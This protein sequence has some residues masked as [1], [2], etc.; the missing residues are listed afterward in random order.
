VKGFTGPNDLYNNNDRVKAV[1][2][3]HIAGKNHFQSAEYPLEDQV[4]GF[5]SIH[6]AQTQLASTLIFT[7]KDVYRGNKYD[8]VCISDIR[9]LFQGQVIPYGNAAELLAAQTKQSQSLL[10]K[11]TSQDVLAND[12]AV[13]LV[14]QDHRAYFL[15]GDGRAYS[16]TYDPKANVFTVDESMSYRLDGTRLILKQKVGYVVSQRSLG[17]VPDGS[18]GVT[19]NGVYFSRFNPSEPVKFAEDDEL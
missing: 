5:Q 12:L 11:S 17:I 15:A 10:G 18:K 7:I 9:L 14:S 6:F 19:I 3:S 13:P 16:G 1:Q 4:P 2:I 8:D